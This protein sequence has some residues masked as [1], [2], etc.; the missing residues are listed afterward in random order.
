MFTQHEAVMEA[1]YYYHLFSRASYASYKTTGQHL[2]FEPL[3][4]MHLLQE[5][6]DNESVAQI[7]THLEQLVFVTAGIRHE[8]ITT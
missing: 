8:K 4:Y 2:T 6:F 1:S 3:T 5:R 7:L